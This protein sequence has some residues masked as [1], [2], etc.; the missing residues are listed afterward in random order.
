[1]PGPTERASPRKFLARHVWSVSLSLL[2]CLMFWRL[3]SEMAEGELDQ[4]DRA[5]SGWLEPSRGRFDFPMLFLTRIGAFWSMASIC[6]AGAFALWLRGKRWEAAY[7]L[8]CGSGAAVWCTCLKLVFHRVRPEETSLYLLS[9]PSSFSFPSGHT[10][11]TAGVIGS[12]IVVTFAMRARRPL[13]LSVLSLGAL[14]IIGVALS[15]VYF[16]VHFPSDILGGQLG[17]LAW[18]AAVTGWF[19]PRLLPNEAV[20]RP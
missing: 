1:M 16:G 2:S 20:L 19:Y 8:A 4:F 9:L 3:G 14:L 17:A 12:L 13:R 10:M 15:R 7:V 18:V 11:G 5:I 6:A